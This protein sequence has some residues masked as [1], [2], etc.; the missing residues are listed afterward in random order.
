MANPDTE[1][2]W[3]SII[4]GVD[5]IDN[6]FNNEWLLKL[7]KKIKSDRFE[8]RGVSGEPDGTGLNQFWYL[9][10]LDG[11]KYKKEVN[12]ISSHFPT[13]I[14][15]AYVNYQTFG[16]HGDFHQDDGEWT[17]LIY[18]NPEWS[19][20]DG[21]GTE[22]QTMDMTSVVSYPVFNRVVKFNANFN[23]RALPNIRTN[24]FR[25]TVAF[26]TEEAMSGKI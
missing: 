9:D 21:G 26:K 16:Q 1:R 24:A 25:Y 3:K 5:Y 6:F 12:Y 19:Y 17:Y 14:V 10:L 2:G 15:R 8:F 4:D 13:S 11:K 7:Y 22:F 23:H 18:I 20:D